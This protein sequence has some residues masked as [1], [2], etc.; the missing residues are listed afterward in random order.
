ML[1]DGSGNDD[2]DYLV[3]YFLPKTDL[4]VLKNTNFSWLGGFR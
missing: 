4:L 2:E 1:A 3:F